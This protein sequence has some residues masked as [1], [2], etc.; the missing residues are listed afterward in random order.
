MEL[1]IINFIESCAQNV[2]VDLSVSWLLYML[3]F[4]APFHDGNGNEEG[5]TKRTDRFPKHK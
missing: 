3:Y 5:E 1:K 2:H 4:V